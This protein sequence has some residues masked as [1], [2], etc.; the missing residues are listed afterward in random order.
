MEPITA[1]D[2]FEGLPVVSKQ[3]TSNGL[4]SKY[5]ANLRFWPKPNMSPP[6]ARQ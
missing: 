5:T 4:G 6:P 3:P 1:M 2:T